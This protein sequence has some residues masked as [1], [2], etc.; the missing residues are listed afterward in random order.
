MDLDNSGSLD[1]TEFAHLLCLPPSSGDVEEIFHLFDKNG[2]GS[3]GM[4]C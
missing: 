3:L 2:D 4:Q 1:E